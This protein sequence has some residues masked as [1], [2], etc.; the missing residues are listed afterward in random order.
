M[1]WRNK[2]ICFNDPN[3]AYWLSYNIEKI[4]YAKQGCV[5]CPVQEEC[6]ISVIDDEHVVGVVAGTSEFDRLVMVNKER[7]V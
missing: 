2:A 5:R 3:S 1:S 7:G 6:L 4:K